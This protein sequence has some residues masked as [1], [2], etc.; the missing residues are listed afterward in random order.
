MKITN[1]RIEQNTLTGRY[2]HIINVDNKGLVLPSVRANADHSILPAHP[3]QLQIVSEQI[4]K[5]INLL[6]KDSNGDW[7][8]VTSEDV[9]VEIIRLM[10]AAEEEST[11][12]LVA[13]VA[14]GQK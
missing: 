8:K 2:R 10:S 14:G 1:Y 5:L 9:A 11:W 6:V 4:A 12:N 3:V 13:V 7:P